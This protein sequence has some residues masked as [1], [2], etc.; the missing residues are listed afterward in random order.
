MGF[1][2]YISVDNNETFDTTFWTLVCHALFSL[3]NI[4]T[5]VMQARNIIVNNYGTVQ[6]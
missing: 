6:V 3:K 2:I 5:T 1:A 4:M